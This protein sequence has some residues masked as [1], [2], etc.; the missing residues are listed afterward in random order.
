MYVVGR[1]PYYGFLVVLSVL[2]PADVNTKN[3]RWM[4]VDAARMCRRRRCS[5]PMLL[6][7]NHSFDWL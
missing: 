5:V 1:V 2:G 7:V 3:G 6:I 4:V